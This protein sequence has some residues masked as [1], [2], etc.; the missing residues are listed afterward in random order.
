MRTVHFVFL[1]ALAALATA[2]CQSVPGLT[3]LIQGGKPDLI[4]LP[5]AGFCQSGGQLR[6]VIRNQE[7]DDADGSTTNITFSRG[8]S[9]QLATPG[10]DGGRIVTLDAVSIPA[11]CF[12]P[13]CLVTVTVDAQDELDESNE[14]NNVA[15]ERCPAPG[16]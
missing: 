12:A 2:H 7:A 8:S 14:D 4:P 10:I 15:E 5:A 3:T 9:I 11:E 6:V 1:A 16:S 13:D